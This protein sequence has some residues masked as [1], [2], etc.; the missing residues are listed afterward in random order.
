MNLMNDFILQEHGGEPSREHLERVY[1]FALMWSV[2]ALLELDDRKKMEVWL[3]GNNSFCLNLPNIP[4]DSE[5]T[6]FDYHVS[7][8]GKLIFTNYH[9]II[10]YILY[11]LSPKF[12][13][14]L[15]F[16]P[17]QWVHWSNRVEEYIYP[18]DSTPQYRSILVPNVDNVRTDFLIQTI[19]KQGK[20]RL[21]ALH[22]ESIYA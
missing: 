22:S 12:G 2:G 5:D 21:T 18:S 14:K 17:G 7:D 20:V 16:Y 10:P 13:T 8:D 11:T 4:F 19:A 6:M 9:S 1:V 15:V 3:R